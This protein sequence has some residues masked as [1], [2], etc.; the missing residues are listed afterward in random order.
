MIELDALLAE[1][2]SAYRWSLLERAFN[3]G[4]VP[5]DAASIDR[6]DRALASWPDELR[7]VGVPHGDDDVGP[8][9]ALARSFSLFEAD[10]LAGIELLLRRVPERVRMLRIAECDQVGPALERLER[11]PNLG[12]LDLA[13]DTSNEEERAW[14]TLAAA[15]LPT[16]RDLR[17][18]ALRIPSELAEASWW[19]G[20]RTLWLWAQDPG[21]DSYGSLFVP[22]MAP[23]LEV[24]FFENAPHQDVS[25][26]LVACPELRALRKLS[27]VSLDRALVEL[28]ASLDG[29]VMLGATYTASTSEA[30]TGKRLTG[31]RDLVLSGE[32]GDLGMR[33]VCAAFPSLTT[34]R[35]H[36]VGLGVSGC[37]TV[38]ESYRGLEHLTLSFNALGD[39]GADRLAP[40]LGSV[41]ELNLRYCALGPHGSAAIAPMLSNVVDLHLSGNP[42]GPRGAEAL[43]NAPMPNL[44]RL[45]LD[46]CGIELRGALALAASPNLAKITSLD[47]ALSHQDEALW[48]E[49]VRALAASPYA[50]RYLRDELG[51]RLPPKKPASRGFWDKLRGR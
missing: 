16:L 26:L 20:L 2:P 48:P 42:I 27:G 30:L 28:V 5:S 40:A 41:R 14:R 12:T 51:S 4:E 35:A 13:T 36:G 49:G 37:A 34:L 6:I 39:D 17:I 38:A 19:R 44:E 46:G 32:V 43:A 29:L 10:A 3:R 18:T 7:H 23:A 31:V 21:A 24:L 9:L 45:R 8:M 47:L 33:A 1:R 11:F 22:G 15:A 25:H 50:S